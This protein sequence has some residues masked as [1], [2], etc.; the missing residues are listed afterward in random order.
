MPELPVFIILFVV[1]QKIKCPY[2]KANFTVLKG[3]L[4]NHLVV[5]RRD[6]TVNPMISANKYGEG[7]QYA[8]IPIS[9]PRTTLE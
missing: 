7:L 1:F 5:L 4:S 2:R 6:F 3:C 8:F 9:K